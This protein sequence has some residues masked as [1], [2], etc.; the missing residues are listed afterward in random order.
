MFIYEIFLN[1]LASVKTPKTVYWNNMI[2]DKIHGYVPH[3]MIGWCWMLWALNLFIIFIILMN[4]LIGIIS[5]TYDD[6]SE[7]ALILIYQTRASII[8]EISG[9]KDAFRRTKKEN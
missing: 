5:Q 3:L 8:V 9:I 2:K 1:G 4:F 6:V 7:R